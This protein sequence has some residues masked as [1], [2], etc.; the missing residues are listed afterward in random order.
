MVV[1]II[2]DKAAFRSWRRGLLDF[3]PWPP[4]SYPAAVV[5]DA[6]LDKSG[7][8]VFYYAYVYPSQFDQP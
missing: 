8:A 6:R 4:N 3:T 5:Y 2:K 7:R 1:Y